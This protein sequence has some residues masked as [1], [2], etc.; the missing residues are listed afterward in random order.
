VR[1]DFMTARSSV[2]EPDRELIPYALVRGTL[3]RAM[4][5][6]IGHMRELRATYDCPITHLC[7]PPPFRAIGDGTKLPT[8][9]QSNLHLGVSPAPLRR[10]LYELSCDIIRSECAN[11][12][13][14]FM[15]VPDGVTDAEGY[16]LDMYCSQDPTHANKRYGALVLRQILEA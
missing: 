3:E 12:D 9:F 10:K 11:I 4:R 13:I 8:V 14:G 7:T 15:G 1:F 6:A 16:L 2:V 5:R